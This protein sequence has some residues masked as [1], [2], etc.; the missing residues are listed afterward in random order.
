MAD[1]NKNNPSN[2][3]DEIR[4]SSKSWLKVNKGIA[5]SV[6][7]LVAVVTIVL[8]YS[9][10]KLKFNYNIESFFS[11]ENADYQFYKEHINRFEGENNFILIGIKNTQG[12]DEQDFLVKVDS[13][14]K[15]L[16]KKDDFVTKVLSPTNLSKKII[17]P[18]GMPITVPLIHF[19]EKEKIKKDIDAIYQNERLVNSFFSADTQSISIFVEKRE[20]T[21]RQ[22]DKAFLLSLNTMLTNLNFEA[23]YLGG[24]VSTQQFYVTQMKEE[25]GIFFVLGILLLLAFLYFSFKSFW[26]VTIPI[27]V[28]IVSLIWTLGIMQI[29]GEELTLMMVML[30][31]MLFVIGVSDSVHIINKFRY[32]F[33]KTKD[34]KEALMITIKEIGVA[35]FLTSI[36]TAIGF[37][38]L[39]FIDIAPL[40]KFG[41]YTAIGIM[42][43]YLVSIFLIP[44]F[45]LLLKIRFPKEQ[46][47]RAFFQLGLKKMYSG[48]IEHK[49]W[50]VIGIILVIAI[51]INGLSYFRVNNN[52]LDD[53]SDDTKLKQDM[54]FFENNFSGIVP[55]E[56]AVEANENIF[57][58]NT[59][60]EIEQVEN[61]LAE[62]YKAGFLISPTS[63]IKIANSSLN[64]G[65][66]KFYKLPDT[67]RKLNKILKQLKRFGITKRY[68]KLVS[69]DKKYGRITAK[70]KDIGSTKVGDLNEGLVKFIESKNFTTKFIITG[71]SH[72]LN[73]SNRNISE[74]VVKGIILAM[75]LILLTV[76]ILFSSIRIALYSLLPN[77]L[78]LIILGGL[79]GYFNID[80]KV[81][82]SLLFT[83]VL[84]IS[85]D[86]TIHILTKYRLGRKVG[87]NS[88]RALF[89]SFQ[90]T[91]WSVVVTSFIIAAG[92][93]IFLVSDFESTFYMGLL[94]GGSLV[95]ALLSNLIILP[96]LLGGKKKATL[97]R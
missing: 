30:P 28:L 44:S 63:I 69:E 52:F 15:K 47:S 33:G 36:T 48:I 49:K 13:L 89:N 76:A 6:L 34:R 42:I 8:G 70:I 87:L 68:Q 10:F 82:T 22:E 2:K 11:K 95:T 9:A 93:I 71:A 62:N 61:Y 84:G 73:Q 43:T 58:Y 25:M 18:L 21:T 83:I 14:S 59:L 7:L 17:T 46:R 60:H 16:L 1:N 3:K 31:T 79:M 20:N 65:G 72:L 40:Q 4:P 56:I 26:G 51:S 75:L 54:L 90:S 37:G 50:F 23:Y 97:H 29:T 45:L 66:N 5:Y 85:V 78:P 39:C 64:G 81:T 55:F 35:I 24:R 92:F 41:I 67:E 94:V 32:E 86:D 74:G 88:E 96:L 91:G 38:S 27:I 19:N 53:L 77:L 57:N 12:I 80:L